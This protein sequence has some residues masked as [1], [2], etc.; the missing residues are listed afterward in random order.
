[1]GG[2]QL[3]A[4]QFQYVQ[5]RCK[6]FLRSRFVPQPQLQRRRT[7]IA[8]DRRPNTSA[9]GHRPQQSRHRALAVGTGDGRDRRS[10]QSRQQLDVTPDRHTSRR[11]RRDDRG[12]DRHTRADQQSGRAGECLG[13]ETAQMARHIRERLA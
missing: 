2:F 1:M 7:E 13:R 10:R 6:I 11:C 12:R 3:E 4:G 5:L 9:F 8:A